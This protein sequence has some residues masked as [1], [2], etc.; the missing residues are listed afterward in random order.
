M[1]FSYTYE[2]FDYPETEKVL[3]EMGEHMVNLMRSKLADNGTNASG[4]LSNSIRI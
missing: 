3:R 4:N 2:E 1:E